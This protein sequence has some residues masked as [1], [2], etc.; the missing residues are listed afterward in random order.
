MDKAEEGVRYGVTSERIFGGWTDA[1]IRLLI[2][3]FI[4]VNLACC[5]FVQSEND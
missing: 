4:V 1:L 2:P 5:Y 3:N